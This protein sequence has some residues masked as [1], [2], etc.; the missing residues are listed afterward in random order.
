[1]GTVARMD[2]QTRAA[3]REEL[4]RR[5]PWLPAQPFGPAAVEAG[6]CDRCGV[7]ARLVP[8]CGPIS[9]RYLGRGCLQQVGADA[10]CA[11]H[12]STFD[13]AVQWAADLPPEADVAARLWWVATGEVRMDLA[14]RSVD[15]LLAPDAGRT[16]C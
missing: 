12:E 5:Y 2:A 3:V 15:E 1:M 9:F 4:R 7:E 10:F 13:A 11:G 16:S 14:G 8:T 6:E